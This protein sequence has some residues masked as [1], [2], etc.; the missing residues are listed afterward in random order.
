[1]PESENRHSLL[2][3]YLVFV[4]IIGAGFFLPLAEAGWLGFVI[5]AILFLLVS[6]VVYYVVFQSEGNRAFQLVSVKGSDSSLKQSAVE[7]PE[8]QAVEQ[9]GWQ[10]F[11]EAFR[12]YCSDFYTVVMQSLITDCIGLYMGNQHSDLHFFSGKIADDLLEGPRRINP[13]GVIELCFEKKESVLEGNLPI[14]SQLCGIDSCDIRSALA[15]PL[16]MQSSIVG[17]LAVGSMTVDHFSEDDIQIL[18]RFGRLMTR[19]MAACYTGLRWETDRNVYQVHLELEKNLQQC[20]DED[21]IADAFI[22]QVR[23]LLSIDRFT[24]CKRDGEEG[25]VVYVYG[26]IDH[27]DRGVRFPLDEGLNGWVLRR[28]APLIIPDIE[29]GRYIRPRYYKDEDV[30]H[31]LHSYLGIPLSRPGGEAWGCLSFENRASDMYTQKT[32]DIIQTLAI[33][34]KAALE[35]YYS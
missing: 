1:M 11:N 16:M 9:D 14:G 35:A 22:G 10:G 28:N 26:Q 15:V 13:N 6:C 32:A 23:K 4:M 5:K 29:E 33:P 18:L 31:G 20:V 3:I 8:L 30:K 27:I 34:L 21:T 7:S 25:A 2:I 24:F 12:E 19:V 17:V